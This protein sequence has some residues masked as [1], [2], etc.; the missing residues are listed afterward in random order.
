MKIKAKIRKKELISSLLLFG[1][2]KA[3][4]DVKVISNDGKKVV[5]LNKYMNEQAM[6]L[7]ANLPDDYMQKIVIS[8]EA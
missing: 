6:E 3:K 8:D 1:I 2:T 4:D 7:L 5:P